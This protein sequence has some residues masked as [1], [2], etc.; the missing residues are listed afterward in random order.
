MSDGVERRNSIAHEPEIILDPI[1]KAKAEARNG[2]QQYDYGVQTILEAFDRKSF[3]LRPSL[4]LALQRE[5][6]RGLS[7]YAGNYRPGG[8]DI[9]GSK[10]AP[11]KAHLV[12]ELVEEMCDYVND[13]WGTATSLHLAAY[14]MWRLNWT[15]PFADGNGRTSRILSFVVLSIH[16]FGIPP[17]VP[18]I[19]DLIVEN[20]QPYFQALDAAD[21]AWSDGRID[22]SVMEQLLESLL[23]KQLRS[24]LRQV[25]SN[26]AGDAE[27][28]LQS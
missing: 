1:E 10:H 22:L 14:I 4:V 26:P 27:R 25:G 23:E 13:N 20:R 21:Q 12:P 16:S 5:A 3:K 15:H 18:T 7:A 28:L 24:F 2:L 8:V 6:L 17:G 19:P 11:P 9:H